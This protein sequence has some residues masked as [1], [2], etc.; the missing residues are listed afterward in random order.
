MKKLA[1][2]AAPAALAGLICGML[3][4]DDSAPPA[5]NPGDPAA[6]VWYIEHSA[7][8]AKDADASGVAAV[9]EAK[10]LLRS[11]EPQVEIDFFNKAL[12]DTKSRPIQRE[13]RMTLADLYKAQGQNDKALDQL[14]QLM[15]DQ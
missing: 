14:Q 5:A 9:L 1:A 6:F 10:E 8:V 11:K 2:V 13:I 15:M 12:Y 3:K 7:A 4:A